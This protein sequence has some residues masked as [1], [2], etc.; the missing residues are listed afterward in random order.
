MDV[1]TV[2][3]E[4]SLS[5]VIIEQLLH[6]MEMTQSAY[7]TFLPIRVQFCWM[8]WPIMNALMLDISSVYLNT[9]KRYV[10]A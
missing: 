5:Q 2:L 9:T 4:Y 8:I 1:K 10:N 7:T 3:V 6:Q